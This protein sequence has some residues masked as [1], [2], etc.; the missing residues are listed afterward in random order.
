[1]TKRR[2]RRPRP[3]DPKFLRKQRDE[4]LKEIKMW[5][6]IREILFYA[7]FLCILIVISYRSVSNNSYSYKKTMTQVF[8]ETND[9]KKSFDKVCI[10][11]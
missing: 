11:V 10:V 8:I 6:I 7:F 9:T 2:S 4:R 1:M 3:P 5:A